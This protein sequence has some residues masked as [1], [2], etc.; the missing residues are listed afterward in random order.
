MKKQKVP[1]L[2]QLFY[3]FYCD[4]LELYKKNQPKT[5]MSQ[6][7]SFKTTENGYEVSGTPKIHL[8]SA[9][10][11]FDNTQEIQRLNS[12]KAIVN[13]INNSPEILKTDSICSSSP[14][15]NNVGEPMYKVLGT[16]S[17]YGASIYI[18][19]K[20]I[21]ENHNNTS[22]QIKW[23]FKP[24]KLKDVKFDKDILLFRLKNKH[25]FLPTEK[26][27]YYLQNFEIENSYFELQVG[28]KKVKLKQLS[29]EE[30]SLMI[31]SSH[32]GSEDLSMDAGSIKTALVS[33]DL[34]DQNDVKKIITL[35]RV[36]K[37][38]EFRVYAIG[39]LKKEL[40]K[41]KSIK[42]NTFA[43]VVEKALGAKSAF[44]HKT[45]K[46]DKNEVKSFKKLFHGAYE[47][48]PSFEFPSECLGLLHTT[49]DKFKIPIIFYILESFFPKI[50][51]ENTYRLAH[52]ITKILKKPYSFSET[53]R[54]FYTLRSKIVHG[55]KQNTLT[56]TIKKIQKENGE[57]CSSIQEC[58]K[59]LEFIMRETWKQ[60]L[61]RKL[62]TKEDI[63]AE[64]FK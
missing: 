31:N 2:K 43:N 19:A 16:E 36:F 20:E 51:T 21:F 6:Q 62:H 10:Y 22:V 5:G 48:M 23:D 54:N 42:I 17:S 3:N 18:I 1:N 27:F 50:N 63:E 28:E 37:E 12:F 40:N 61:K 60:V 47:D 39:E 52:C 33:N 11:Y 55:D 13:Y 8:L 46:L 30:K 24:C 7:M 64:I 25:S 57:P 49:D 14:D 41:K 15:E 29:D 32:F 38:G 34:L 53:V 26:Y 45:Y 44:F 4:V 56:K 35:L 58:V 9:S 59:L